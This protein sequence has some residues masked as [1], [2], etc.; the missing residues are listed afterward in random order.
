[1]LLSD[2]QNKAVLFLGFEATNRALYRVLR[3]RYPTLVVA[4]A[5]ANAEL[6]LPDD[7]YLEC[8]LGPDYLSML[9][10]FDV[11]IRSPGVRYWPEVRRVAPRVTTATNLFFAEVR[12]KTQATIIAVTGTKGKSTTTSLIAEGAR[13]AGRHTLLLGN[14]NIQD[15]DAVGEVKNDTVIC[16]E[17]SSYML[18]DF[19]GRP[20][21]AVWLNAFPEHMDWHYTVEDYWKAKARITRE[22]TAKDTFVYT[23]GSAPL[24]AAAA[25]TLA[26]RV[27]LG[28]ASGY[29]LDAHA[30]W[31]GERH[32]V[33][34]TT[35][36]LLG[37]HNARNILAAA[38]ALEAAAIS[39]DG[40]REAVTRFEGLPHRLQSLGI[41]QG[42]T[43]V[44][45]AI[46]TT[47]EST[48]EAIRAFEGK[49]G[50]IVLG[51]LDRGYTYDAL[52]EAVA[53]SRAACAVLMPG[54]REKIGFALE[55]A[56]FAGVIVHA[57]TMPDIVA[58]LYKHTP[59]GK[60]ALLSTAAP[61]YDQYKNY[62]DQGAQFAAAVHTLAPTP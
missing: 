58:A 49:L 18:A 7:P 13:A 23:P 45:D 5:D 17:L 48:I 25:R 60:V 56:G 6:A 28:I 41:Y 11:I 46:S 30:L 37:D 59:P 20:N 31:Y 61:S 42:I 53:A 3:E 4:V 19:T 1:M 2:L 47:P 26:K 44:D 14:I 21:V 33:D 50:S 54:G 12:S 52:G 9:E 38:A 10:D 39:L 32:L 55:R 8:M 62:E 57:G 24:D 34:R 29:H 51:G 36:R 15:W 40:L 22:Q 27:A 43:F 35:I 16:Y